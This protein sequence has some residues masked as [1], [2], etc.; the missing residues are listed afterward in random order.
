MTDS[1]ESDSMDLSAV[2]LEN[3]R[4]LWAVVYARLGD[5]C[6][7]DDVL[8]EVSLAAL[9]RRNSQ[10][11]IR[12]VKAWLYQIAVR[13]VVLFQRR[14]YRYRK[15][16]ENYSQSAPLGEFSRTL[17][18]VALGEKQTYVQAALKRIKP[19]DRQVLLMKY[20]EELSCR[21]I[22]ELLG[23]RETTIQTRLLRA[24]RRLR[25]QLLMHEDFRDLGHV[26]S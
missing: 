6:A 20:C 18:L 12:Q 22:A 7:T 1:I 24:R 23:V 8:Q 2:F 16:V 11:D 5:H 13:Q 17:E 26:E 10:G 9:R 25:E 21:R 14:E 19:S 15:R 4:W 3:H